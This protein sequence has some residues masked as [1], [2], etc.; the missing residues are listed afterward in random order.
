MVA[1]QSGMIAAQDIYILSAVERMNTDPNEILTNE[2][3]THPS[4]AV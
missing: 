3:L 2:T 4:E 1:A